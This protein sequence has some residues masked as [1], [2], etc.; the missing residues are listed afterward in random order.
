MRL[1]RLALQRVLLVLVMT[2]IVLR[3]AT[4]RVVVLD[5]LGVLLHSL[6]IHG[7]QDVQRKLH[8]RYE[9]ITPRT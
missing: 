9:G 6:R 3:L 5:M 8:V 4:C 7:F 2:G 1:P